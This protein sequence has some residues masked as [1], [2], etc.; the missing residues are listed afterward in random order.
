MLFRQLFD[1]ETSTYTYL[2]ADEQTREA[3]LIDSVKEQVDRDLQIVDDLELTLVYTLET[4]V[5]ADHITGASTIRDRL[6]TRSVVAA[7]GGAS[8]GDLHVEEGDEVTF[9]RHR[10]RVLTT[11]GHTHGCLSFVL[12]DQSMVFTGDALLIRG[13]GRTDFQQGSSKTLYHS[14]HEKIFALP[15][16]TLIYPGHDYKG[17]TVSTVGEEKRLNP[18]LGGGK[19]EAEFVEIMSNLKLAHPKKIAIAVPANLNCGVGRK[20][21]PEPAPSPFVAGQVVEV[22]PPWLNGNGEGIFVVDVRQTEEYRGELGRVPGAVSV[23]LAELP[24]KARDWE[25]SRP[26]VTICHSGR[27]SLQAAQALSDAGFR[28]VGS[29]RGGMLAWNEAGLPKLSG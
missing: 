9:G 26:I 19:T 4:H 22:D 6:K 23:P 11:P 12:D 28:E 17:R 27:R 10:L 13:C 8:C 3:V 2:L 15:D 21:E 5:H 16:A 14:V 18:R 24:A 7:E 29:M 25:R 20:P 1:A